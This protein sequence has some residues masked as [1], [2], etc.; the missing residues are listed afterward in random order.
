MK[1]LA[2][3]LIKKG[4]SIITSD[5]IYNLY[6]QLNANAVQAKIKRCLKNKNLKRLYK[7]V[8]VINPVFLKKNVA[9]ESVAQVID[10]K[11][12][13]SGLA[14]LRFHDLIPETINFKTFTGTKSAKI[15][16]ENMNFEIKKV[17]DDQLNFGIQTINMNGNNIRIADP[18]R[19]IMDILMEQKLTPKNRNQICAF[20]RIDEDE[21]ETIHW[22]NA[23]LYSY[24]YRHSKLAKKIAIAMLNT[25][26]TK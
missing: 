23:E 1:N 10:Q 9:E 26:L 14:A 25:G 22:E 17:A 12:F 15:H 18:V 4:N 24:K 13:L 5:D 2:L 6:P 8:Y 16:T 20:F 11:S 19:A 3:E 7:G 21:A